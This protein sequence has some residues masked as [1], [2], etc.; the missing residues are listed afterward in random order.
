VFV[1]PLKREVAS[2]GLNAAISSA[3]SGMA[4][5][6]MTLHFLCQSQ[7][8][9]HHLFSTRLSSPLNVLRGFDE[10]YAAKRRESKK[11]RNHTPV[12]IFTKY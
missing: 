8:H 1:F 7:Y 9:L 6:A 5:V 3:F 11:T 4:G 10:S 12:H 2:T